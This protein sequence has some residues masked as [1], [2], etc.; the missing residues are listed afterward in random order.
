MCGICQVGPNGT[1]GHQRWVKRGFKNGFKK[2]EHLK[3]INRDC[4]TLRLTLN[5]KCTKPNERP[6]GK[7]GPSFVE[8]LQEMLFDKKTS[9]V[10]IL[11]EGEEI[12]CH[13]LSVFQRL[14]YF[15]IH[16][17]CAHFINTK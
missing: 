3:N 11:C 14:L 16:S 7:T 1:K 13:K 10:I 12:P 6:Y 8:R 5:I 17:C 4:C 2:S 15:Q 9:D